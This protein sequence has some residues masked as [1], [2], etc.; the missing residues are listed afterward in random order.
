MIEIPSYLKLVVSQGQRRANQSTRPANASDEAAK[1]DKAHDTVTLSS[2][3]DPEPA[4]VITLAET[5]RRLTGADEPVLSSEEAGYVLTQLQ[6]DLPEL[7][8]GV[9]DLHDKLDRSRV[10]DLLAPLVDN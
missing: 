1:G 4:V 6:R 3:S 9:H 2:L 5:R 8:P 7:G 10:L